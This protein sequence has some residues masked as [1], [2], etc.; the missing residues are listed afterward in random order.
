MSTSS[1]VGDLFQTAGQ[2][3]QQLG[4][5][6]TQLHPASEPTPVNAKWTDV[7]IDMMLNSVKR[8]CTDLNTISETIKSRTIAQ[9]RTQ[10]KRKAYEEAGLSLPPGPAPAPTPTSSRQAGTSARQAVASTPVRYVQ[11]SVGQSNEVTL[12]A[13]NSMDNDLD[14]DGL[15]SPLRPTVTGQRAAKKV[16]L[17][18]DSS[19]DQ[20]INV[21]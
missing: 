2:A 12:S 6:T 10:M 20:S 9:I 3:L 18:L 17:D 14:M 21:V 5:L 4:E 11:T 1:K 15:G 7:E 13:L 8:F 19:D 16:K